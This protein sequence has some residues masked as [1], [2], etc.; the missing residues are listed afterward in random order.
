MIKD[1]RLKARSSLQSSAGHCGWV[2]SNPSGLFLTRFFVFFVI[3]LYQR[4]GSGDCLKDNPNFL[5]FD[6]LPKCTAGQGEDL[7]CS[8]NRADQQ[9]SKI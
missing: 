7:F 6:L 8:P 4:S 3:P 9:V 1:E 2:K 5:S